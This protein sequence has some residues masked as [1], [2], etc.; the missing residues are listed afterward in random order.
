[1][2]FQ[3][4]SL[5]SSVTPLLIY[6]VLFV[7]MAGS[8]ANAIRIKDKSRYRAGNANTLVTPWFIQGGLDAVIDDDDEDY[9]G[10]Q[11]SLGHFI[12]GSS[13]VRFNLGISNL[14][15]HYDNDR[16]FRHDGLVYIF[17]DFGR[18][19]VSGATFSLLGMFYS[20]PLPEPRVYFGLGPR[21]GIR[22]ARPDVFVTSYDDYDYEWTEPVQYDDGSMVSFGMEGALGFEWFLGRQMSVFAEYGATIQNEWYLLEYDNYDSFDRRIGETDW[23]DDGIHV[24]DSH[25]KLGM[26]VYF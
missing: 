23:F 25:I 22:D 26:S 15:P 7:F 3:N 10:F 1:M 6:L 12:S 8:T 14:R 18:F 17:D 9:N 21:L 2:R 4:L 11:L 16:V 13:A 24:D 20:S 19:D 5:R